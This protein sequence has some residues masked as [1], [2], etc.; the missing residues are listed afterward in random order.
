MQTKKMHLKKPDTGTTTDAKSFLVGYYQ[1]HRS[2]L[3]VLAAVVGIIFVALVV[4]FSVSPLVPSI[5]TNTLTAIRAG[6]AACQHGEHRQ[7]ESHNTMPAAQLTTVAQFPVGYFLENVA[8][9]A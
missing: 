4:A 2:R 8:V 1:Q 3:S 9:R 7:A 6:G 5:F